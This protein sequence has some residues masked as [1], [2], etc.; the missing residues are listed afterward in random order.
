MQCLGARIALAPSGL[1]CAKPV[2]QARPLSLVAAS[3]SP[4]VPDAEPV[5]ADVNALRAWREQCPELRAMWAGLTLVP[6]YAQL[7]LTLAH[8]AQLKLTLA[9]L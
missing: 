2:R 7:E 3:A 5:E 9:A 1:R 4:T 8:S 6:I